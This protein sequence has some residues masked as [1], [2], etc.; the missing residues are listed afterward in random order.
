MTREVTV[1]EFCGWLTEQLSQE[2]EE[3]AWLYLAGKEWT[4]TPSLLFAVKDMLHEPAERPGPV[5]FT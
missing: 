4:V 1:A 3:D 5:S 2:H